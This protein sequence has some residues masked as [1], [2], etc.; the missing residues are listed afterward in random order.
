ML[1]SVFQGTFGIGMKHIKPLAW[2]AWWLIYALVAMVV[3]PWAWA[4]VAVPD[5]AG[6]ILSAPHAAVWTAAFF[7]FL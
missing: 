4:L 6:S 3:I 1:A 2:E 5:L 7:G